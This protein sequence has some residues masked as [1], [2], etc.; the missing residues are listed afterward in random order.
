M[1]GMNY[2]IGD[3]PQSWFRSV[4]FPRPRIAEPQRREQ[5]KRRGFWPAVMSHNA[6]EQ[7]LWC[8]FSVFHKNVEVPVVIENTR[9]EQFVLEL[10]ARATLTRIYEVAIR[11]FALRVLVEVL[12][13]GVRGRTVD[14]EVV[15]LHVLAVIAFAVGEA[16]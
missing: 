15:F 3:L 14:I 13:V 9:V 2:A 5:M 8:R 16:E 7:V 6:N 11:E 10:V 12:H 1:G 4:P